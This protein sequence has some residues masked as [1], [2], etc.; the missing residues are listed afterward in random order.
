M[1]Q[2]NEVD[3]RVLGAMSGAERLRM[4]LR[5]AGFKTLTDFAFKVGTHAQ[6]ISYCIN[7]DREYPEIRDALALHLGLERSDVDA[8]IEGASS[9]RTPA[10]QE[11]W[12][13]VHAQ[14]VAKRKAS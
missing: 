7:G 10:E 12:D 11:V 8:L 2:V 3:A 1:V 6:T 13:K 4:L 5:D 14:E 9:A